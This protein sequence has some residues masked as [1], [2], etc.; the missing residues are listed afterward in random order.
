MNRGPSS[1]TRL[2]ATPRPP[3]PATNRPPWRRW[4]TLALL[5]LAL[6]LSTLPAAGRNTACVEN[7][8]AHA[9]RALSSTAAAVLE[10]RPATDLP[11]ACPRIFVRS[12]RDAMTPTL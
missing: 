4:L 2:H 6:P 5:A 1:S 9:L 12:V 3:M 7:D 11:D 8:I 10:G